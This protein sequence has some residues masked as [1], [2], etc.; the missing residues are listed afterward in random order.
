MPD[1]AAKEEM[2]KE[3]ANFNISIFTT[4]KDLQINQLIPSNYSVRYLY[5]GFKHLINNTAITVGCVN[6]KLS[7]GTRM[8]RGM[9]FQI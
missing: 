1:D 9:E 6:K 4:E 5:N 2:K 7:A 3:Y 8:R